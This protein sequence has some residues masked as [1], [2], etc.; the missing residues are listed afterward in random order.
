M[1]A[2]GQTDIKLVKVKNYSFIEISPEILIK[3]LNQTMEEWVDL[4]NKNGYEEMDNS[5]GIITH[6]K[7]NLEERIQAIAKNKLGIVSITWLDN[8]KTSMIQQIQKKVEK[9]F[10]NKANNISYYTYGKYII[11]LESTR[12][13]DCVLETVYIKRQ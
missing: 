11:G 8:G 3:F 4:M 9:S 6:S 5:D 10:L 1:L 7:G 12:G 2:F 13:N